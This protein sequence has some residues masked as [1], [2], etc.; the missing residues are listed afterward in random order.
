[1]GSGRTVLDVSDHDN[2]QVSL[3]II[4]PIDQ[5]VTFSL[6]PSGAS[7]QEGYFIK[8]RE[9]KLSVDDYGDQTRQIGI[10]P[11]LQSTLQI[12]DTFHVRYHSLPQPLLLGAVNDSAYLQIG[13]PTIRPG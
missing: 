8:L 1:M 2:F 9:G 6:A 4:Q 3:S 10:F 11:P 7:D 12:G 13:F 5:F